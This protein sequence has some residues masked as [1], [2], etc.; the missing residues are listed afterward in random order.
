MG[1]LKIEQQGPQNYA[2]TR[3]Q[4]NERFKQAF[5]YDLP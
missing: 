4:I 2:P 1:A 3:A 5:G